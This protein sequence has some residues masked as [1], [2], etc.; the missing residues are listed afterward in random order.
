VSARAWTLDDLAA[1]DTPAARLDPRA[2]VLATFAYVAVVAS[3]GR[4]DLVRLAP[5]ALFPAALTAL[6]DV[7]LRPLLLR[8]ALASPFALGVAAF[9]PFL[10]RSPAL[11]LGGVAISGG[12]IGFATI[13]AKFALSL[14]AALLLVAT[15]GFDAVCAALRRLG[16]PRAMVAQ[17]LL[18]YRYLFVLA[19]EAG[20]TLR[21][22]ALRSPDRPRPTLRVAGT[23]LGQLLVRALGRAERIHA[24][25]LC[26]GFDGDLRLRRAWRLSARDA[27]FAAA[28]AALLVAARALDVPALVAGLG[29]I[30]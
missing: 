18:T 13:L 19:G 22:H 21:A 12:A 6:G 24:A 28:T 11:T 17:L 1:R 27:L 15:T 9:E 23:L 3:F 20:R 14:S 25:M 5:L 29:G 4:H 30:R 8:L 2:K 26:R 10:D 7:P 16:A